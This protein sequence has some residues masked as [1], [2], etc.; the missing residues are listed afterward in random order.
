MYRPDFE[1]LQPILEVVTLL[2]TNGD[3]LNATS[4]DQAFHASNLTHYLYTPIGDPNKWT[5]NAW[6]T[7]GELIAA[8]TRLIAFLDY[9]ADQPKIPHLLNEFSYFWET[10][11]DTLDPSFSQCKI[12][13]PAGLDKFP[14]GGAEDVYHEP[15]LGYEGAGDGG[16]G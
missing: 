3:H 10:P 7:L 15:F 9:G 8:N 1:P 16:T 5:I 4:F 11:F 14:G 12:D 13:R 2:L 6:P